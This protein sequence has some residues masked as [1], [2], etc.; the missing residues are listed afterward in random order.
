MRPKKPIFFDERRGV[1]RGR[2]H[3]ITSSG[4]DAV[5]RDLLPAE[6][7]NWTETAA[8]RRRRRSPEA[9]DRRLRD[10]YR[11]VLRE[12]LAARA[13]SAS[14][15]PARALRVSE[16]A[17]EWLDEVSAVRDAQTARHYSVSV[18]LLIE[19]L[20]DFALDRVPRNLG[21]AFCEFL[22]NRGNSD[23]TIN[24]R[25]REVKGFLAWAFRAGLLER[26]PRITGVREARRS[27][28]V[29][30]AGQLL[31]VLARIE[32]A[33]GSAK[34]D[35]MRVSALNQRRAWWMLRHTG[36]RGGEV[37]AL[38]LAHIGPDAVLIRDVPD[39][40]FR[41]KG[42]RE[43]VVPVAPALAEFLRA[44]LAE[45][46]PHERWFLDTG[47]GALQWADTNAMS[48]P[49]SRHFRA[50]GIEGV[51]PLHGFRASVASQLLNSG[52]SPVAV[53]ALL[54]HA[55]I[56]TTM[57]YHNP[58]GLDLAGLLDAHL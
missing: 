3:E 25:V 20:G 13:A 10:R 41:V 24:S 23:A 40:G 53:Q 49:F 36:M 55:N 9:R 6:V 57:G 21:G 51:K 43:A 30:D 18:S 46:R 31:A 44:D 14:E 26:E 29:L 5:K 35:R 7:A 56:Q 50:L 22:R 27:P 32:D 33:L 19:A 45:R 47:D 15:R 52:A 17:Q 8:G 39:A 4:G 1:Y 2:F 48:R 34:S 37:R 58:D 42:R 11:E 28:G 16:A 38:P 12:L 54:R